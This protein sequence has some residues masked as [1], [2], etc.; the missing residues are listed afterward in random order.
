MPEA[1]LIK[2]ISNRYTLL[3]KDHTRLIAMASGK[4]KLKTSPMVGDRCV[5]E[6][7]DDQVVITD[8]LSRTNYLKRPV[9][10]NVNQALIVMSAVK[11]DFS[12]ALVDRFTWLIRQANIEPILVVTKLDL[13]ATDHPVHKAME[14]YEASGMKVV[15]IARGQAMTQLEETIAHKISV[16]TGQSGVGK[17]SLLNRLNPDFVLH[18]QE[19]SKA[20]GRGKHTTRHVELYEV[21]EGFVADTPGF[22][23]LDFSTI[24]ASDLEGLVLEFKPFREQCYF[25]DCSHLNEPKCAVKQAVE[26]GDIPTE[27]YEHYCELMTVLNQ[28]KETYR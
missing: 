22:S 3:T 2:L 21:A 20:L 8:V 11:P 1:L 28:T 19:I 12:S 17:S 26:K 16:L 5:Y 9:I 10:A 23:S 27:R 4:M 14:I 15:R 13:V 18:T 6:F 25:R 7:R 24:P